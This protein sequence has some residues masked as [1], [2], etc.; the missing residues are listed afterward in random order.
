MKKL[1]SIVSIL[2][3][4]TAL[5]CSCG[6]QT[7]NDT[8]NVSGVSAKSYAVYEL[9]GDTDG[10]FDSAMNANPIDAEMNSKLRTEDLSGTREQQVFYDYY[11]TA[12]KN[13]LKQSVKNLENYLS[14]E[15]ISELEASQT[16]WEN[17]IKLKYDTDL[18]IISEKGVSLG[19]QIVASRLIAI[20]DEYREQTF[21]IKYMTM[22]VEN[23]VENPVPSDEQLWNVFSFDNRS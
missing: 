23:N 22:L 17:S 6:K 10:T 18:S 3:L 11:C 19:T 4:S 20:T 8:A 21:H 1:I 12:W 9:D 15:Q 13:E 5:L 7:E 16:A 2:L 14:T